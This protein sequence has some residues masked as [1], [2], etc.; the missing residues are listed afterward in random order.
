MLTRYR[1]IGAGFKLNPMRSR[2]FH[3]DTKP[4]L[5]T[6]RF[7]SLSGF[8]VEVWQQVETRC[9]ALANTHTHRAQPQLLIF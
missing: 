4:A 6:E 3:L 2:H 8:V 7:L 5:R 9:L 1:I